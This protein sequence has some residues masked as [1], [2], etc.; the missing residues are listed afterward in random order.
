M[1]CGR[2]VVGRMALVLAI[3]ILSLAP[4]AAAQGNGRV[5]EQVTPPDKPGQGL[6]IL[7]GFNIQPDGNALAYGSAGAI[8]PDDAAS[9]L[10]MYIGRRGASSWQSAPISPVNTAQQILS[11]PLP[12]DISDDLTKSVWLSLTPIAPGGPG[13]PSQPDLAAYGGSPGGPFSFL[14]DITMS[15]F[16]FNWATPDLS[17][18]AFTGSEGGVNIAQELVGNQVRDVGVDSNEVRIFDCGSQIGE[19]PFGGVGGESRRNAMTDDGSR[20]FFTGEV[21]GESQRVYVRE[22]A[23]TTRELSVSEC[24]PAR[25]PACN[26]P[27]EVAFMGASKD[28]STVLMG[29]AQQLTS[30]DTNS[31]W[32]IYTVDVASGDITRISQGPDPSVDTRAPENAWTSG[33]SEDLQTVYFGAQG[34]LAPGATAGQWNLYVWHAGEGV[35]FVA[36]VDT[37]DVQSFSGA[38]SGSYVTASGNH[39][40]FQTERGLVPEDND[41]ANNNADDIYLYD[42][43]AGTLTFVSPGADGNRS[44]HLPD[45]SADAMAR[46]GLTHTVSED[47]SRV[48]LFTADPM[49]PE[50]ENLSFD[51]YEFANGQ[52]SLVSG[53]TEGENTAPI[54]I[55]ATPSG[56]DVFFVDFAQLLDSDIDGLPDVYDAR[57]G[58]GFPPP[59]STVQP[60]PGCREDACQGPGAGPPAR[61]GIES[62][63]VGPEARQRVVFR[64]ARIGS[65]AR[66]RFARTGRLTLRVR[67]GEGGDLAAA[68]RAR[69]GRRTATV[70]R[71]TAEADGA[72]T[73]RLSLRLSRRARNALEENGRLRVTIRVSFSEANRA[74][75]TRLLLRAPGAD[76]G[77]R[78]R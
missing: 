13:T 62:L 4:S 47:G 64:L 51:I 12:L 30:D 38:P 2:G 57:V 25:V 66:R 27:S 60:P 32:D 11:A 65:R 48:F 76:G 7:G 49:V 59:D 63:I 69:L 6:A 37:F 40:A 54:F 43:E 10:N 8:H 34:V 44:V 19:R 29:S 39:F 78:G 15:D 71:D 46:R 55:G 68:A 70:A 33:V 56:S 26:A 41:T 35:E 17:H 28:G 61:P 45:P 14:A 58:G 73:Y 77:R 1:S 20:I 23:A 22:N 18:V 24:D 50:D 21:C 67:V 75:S 42:R 72:G 53:G 31:S 5:L 16:A 74:R 52:V 9:G 36:T 3:A